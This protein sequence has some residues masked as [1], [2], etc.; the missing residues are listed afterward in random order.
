VSGF[1]TNIVFR[2]ATK[3]ALLITALLSRYC[4]AY[5]GLV[6]GQVLDQSSSMLSQR[7]RAM[8]LV[9]Q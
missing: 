7:G 3:D 2:A 5:L 6:N 8:F 4:F 1:T 9:C